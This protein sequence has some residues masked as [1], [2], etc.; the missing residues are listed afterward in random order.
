MLKVEIFVEEPGGF[1]IAPIAEQVALSTFINVLSIER[2]NVG[3]GGAL[4]RRII[5]DTAENKPSPHRRTES[6][7][8]RLDKDIIAELKR[9]AEENQIN[10]NTLA[11][12]IFDFYVKF[13]NSAKPGFIPLSK[14]AVVELVERC[15]DE[16]TKSIAERIF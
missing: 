15:S 5:L 1:L 2:E 4:G 11:N 9:E 12:Q 13:A 14:A 8:F 3:R 10:L 7:S 16:E 6:I